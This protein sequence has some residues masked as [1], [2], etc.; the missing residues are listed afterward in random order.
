VASLVGSPGAGR[1]AYASSTW[2]AMSR[3]MVAGS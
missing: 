2:P 3:S 1:S